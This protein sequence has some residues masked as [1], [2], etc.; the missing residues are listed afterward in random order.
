MTKFDNLLK[1]RPSSS[2]SEPMTQSAPSNSSILEDSVPAANSHTRPSTQAAQTTLSA[3]SAGTKSS[4]QGPTP[5]FTADNSGL[6][7]CQPVLRADDANLWSKI[8]T[9]IE[10]TYRAML[11][12]CASLGIDAYV[13]RSNAFEFPHAVRFE[14]WVA[15]VA[16][17]PNLTER[18]SVYVGIEPKPWHQYEMEYSIEIENR[19]RKREFGKFAAFASHDVHAL[20]KYLVRNESKP[21]LPKRIRQ[22]NDPFWKWLASIKNEPIE[23]RKDYLVL[24]CG[25]FCLFGFVGLAMASSL[26]DAKEL[27][28]TISLLA[29]ALGVMSSIHV[30]RQPRAVRSTGR[31]LHN[32][33][34]LRIFDAW[35]AVLSGAASS[36]DLMRQR[37]AAAIGSAPI[38]DFK[39]ST[40]RIGYR[41]LDELVVREQIV[42]TARRGIVYCQIYEFGSDLFVGWQS[43]LNRGRWIEKFPGV[44]GID[45]ATGRRAEVRTATP[46]SEPLCEYDYFDAS[47]LTEWTHTQ[48]V[49]LTKQLMKELQIDQEIDFK[50]VRGERGD[51]E[52]KDSEKKHSN[53]LSA[54]FHRKS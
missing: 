50:I 20:L 4:A 17:D 1:R 46:G 10:A 11:D 28:S 8:E 22:P 49:A 31:P 43:F 26:G 25:P 29:L 9:A 53:T 35:Q 34:S 41:V 5:S 16:G 36:A 14:C 37:F 6:E 38:D 47:C 2:D 23:L 40:E 13:A 24:I 48:I 30:A 32:P 54:L 7:Q 19:G 45:K 27:V 42:L 12:A 51:R 44:C 52:Q 3:F 21:L 39:A 18:C 33:R 15:P